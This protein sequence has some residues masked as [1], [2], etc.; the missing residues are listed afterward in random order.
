MML[1][2]Q[3]EGN[4]QGA[5]ATS[6]KQWEPVN[7]A[8]KK[9]LKA[10]FEV[11]Y[12]QQQNNDSEAIWVSKIDVGGFIYHDM[13]IAWTARVSKVIKDWPKLFID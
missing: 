8:F 5:A 6:A 13:W 9:I 4:F 12:R 7:H 10:T 11:K 3:Q 2:A 1:K